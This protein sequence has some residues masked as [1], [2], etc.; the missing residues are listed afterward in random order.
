VM[1][2]CYVEKYF[3]EMLKWPGMPEYVL[4]CM[5]TAHGPWIHV[6]RFG[7]KWR[8]RQDATH[9]ALPLAFVYSARWRVIPVL[10]QA[11]RKYNARINLE[12][13]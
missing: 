8:M 12:P 5:L 3:Q 9:T 4:K 1:R 6:D 11:A 10:Q 13:F 2:R 7:Y